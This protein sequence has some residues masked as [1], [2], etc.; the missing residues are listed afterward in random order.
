M[1]VEPAAR[2]DGAPL[3]NDLLDTAPCGFLSFAEDGSVTRAN[4]T[5]LDLLGY[6]REELV[7]RHVERILTVGSRIFYQTH[8]FPLLRLHGRAEEIFLMLRSK[9]G[10]EIAVLVNAAR[11]EEGGAVVYDCILMRVRER[12]KY[13]GELLRARKAAD[14]ARAETEAQAKKLREA[15]RLLEEQAVEL[16][17]Q[18]QQ[19]QEQTAELEEASE[20]LRVANE[21][22][23]ARTEE[24]EQ[25]RAAAEEAN[26]AK[27]AFL[28]TMSH[29]LRTPLNA[30]GGYAQIL[31]MEIHG[32][33][34][35]AQR[36]DLGRIGRS[37][38]HLLRLINDVLNLARIESGRLEFLV[39][40]VPVAE[41][42]EVVVPMIEPQFFRKGIDF[43][44]NL[45][46]ELV[47]R[48]DREK[49]Q[50]ILINLLG[51]AAKF[52]PDGGHVRL[53]A[54]PAA[55]DPDRLL[56]RVTDTGVGIRAEEL[57]SIF[58]PYVRANTRRTRSTEGSGLGLAIS[59]EMARGMNGDLTAESTPGK[60]STFTLALP[61][62]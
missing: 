56:L 14:E 59:R 27:S 60:G 7:G 12:Q 48:A 58:E 46:P 25:L 31:E 40:D 38:S 32:P 51:N 50:Q 34:T 5:L 35:D 11:R 49:V 42:V 37:Q 23:L 15:N 8:W 61:R 6:A 4:A 3:V 55:R 13:E 16:E 17:L 47:V 10:E 2:M 43:T 53:E 26:R 33:I 28:A 24:A 45:A 62:A 30:I 22:L 9:A 36:E 21:D 52:T 29:E 20:E 19:L 18:Q 1:Q 44:A 57:G 41:I 39:E 54:A